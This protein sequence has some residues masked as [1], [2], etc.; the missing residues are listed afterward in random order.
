MNALQHLWAS[1]EQLLP[2]DQVAELKRR[3]SEDAARDGHHSKY[4]AQAR[5]E[6]E[7]LKIVNTVDDIDYPD[8]VKRAR[9]RLSNIRKWLEEHQDW[10]P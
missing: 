4:R 9:E 6:Q 5:R 8:T 2:A 1:L 7:C 3:Y 10:K